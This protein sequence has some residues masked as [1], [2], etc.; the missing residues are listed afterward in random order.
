[1]VKIVKPKITTCFIKGA[2]AD[3]GEVKEHQSSSRMK[4]TFP[5]TEVP[6]IITVHRCLSGWHGHW[7]TKSTVYF[8]S[9]INCGAIQ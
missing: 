8:L 2:E 6:I 5:E 7:Q 4:S 1:M 9:P 3:M